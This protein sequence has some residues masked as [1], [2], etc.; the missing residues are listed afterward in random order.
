MIDMAPP[1][2]IPEKRICPET[3]EEMTRGV[4]PVTFSYKGHSETVNMPGWYTADGKHGIYNSED[5]KV[6]DAALLRMKAKVKE[7][8][9]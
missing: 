1:K 3:G 6:S 5:T 7:E 8:N 4:R 9:K 2:P